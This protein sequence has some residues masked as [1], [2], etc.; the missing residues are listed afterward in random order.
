MVM[1][2][3]KSYSISAISNVLS[4][5][6]ERIQYNILWTGELD[7][8]LIVCMHRRLFFDKFPSQSAED[9]KCLH[10]FFLSSSLCM[11]MYTYCTRLGQRN[12]RTC[13]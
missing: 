6:C 1:N 9:V 2:V 5:P 11:P 8:N 10:E 13:I 4:Y 3:L 12:Y 7:V